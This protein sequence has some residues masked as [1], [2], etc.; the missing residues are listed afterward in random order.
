[1]YIIPDSTLYI[2]R[3]VPLDT[4]YDHTLW[5]NKADAQDIDE[6]KRAQAAYFA[7]LAKYRL[8]YERGNALTYIRVNRG[9]IKVPYKADDLYDCNYIMFRNRSFGTKWFY[10]FIRSIE[11]VNNTTTEITFELDVMQTW[12]FDYQ[13]DDCFVE[14]EHSVTDYAG[15]NTLPEAVDL[16]D[17]ISDGLIKSGFF[18]DWRIVVARGCG[19]TAFEAVVNLPATGGFY[20]GTYQQVEFDVWPANADSITAITGFLKG[21]SLLNNTDAVLGIFL[22]P[23]D[24]ISASKTDLASSLNSGLKVEGFSPTTRPTRVGTYTPKNNKLLTYPYCFL[25]CTNFEGEDK[26]YHYEYFTDLTGTIMQDPTF[27][28][29][30]DTNIRPAVMLVPTNYMMHTLGTPN[31]PNFAEGMIISNLPECSYLTTDAGAKFVQAGMNLAIGAL[32]KK[33]VNTTTSVTDFTANSSNINKKGNVT[34]GRKTSWNKATTVTSQSEKGSNLY[35]VSDSLLSGISSSGISSNIGQG[36]ITQA[37]SGVDFFFRRLHI[38]EEYA[39]VIDDYF[40]AFGYATK[41]LKQPNCSSRPH[42]NYVKT[43]G[44]TITGSVPCD[45][46]AAICSIYDNGITFWKNGAEVGNYSLDN[47]PS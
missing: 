20:N 12:H 36:S 35:D 45:D 7:S 8:E 34:G 40:S 22:M 6:G 3:N 13:I 25:G 1:M 19:G 32:G 28:I 24:F 31:T 26:E 33:A 41:R 18:D 37:S 4:T 23:V 27:S 16:G 38:R 17:Y 46:M 5:F 15:D 10:A 9:T 29:Y 21:V 39:R 42:W 43:I 11:Y 47:S 44:C 30:T 14:R 2:L